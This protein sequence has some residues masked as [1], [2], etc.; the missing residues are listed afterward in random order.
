MNKHDASKKHGTSI[1]LFVILLLVALAAMG[2][3]AALHYRKKSIATEAYGDECGRACGQALQ[4]VQLSRQRGYAREAELNQRLWETE[5][6]LQGTRRQHHILQA[7]ASV[8]CPALR[9]E[10]PPYTKN[11]L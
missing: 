8:H 10:V 5:E 6:L 4:G 2:W 9:R 3:M 7:R 1:L 11:N